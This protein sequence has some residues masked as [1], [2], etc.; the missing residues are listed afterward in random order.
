M[1]KLKYKI[2]Y[3]RTHLIVKRKFLMLFNI[4]SKSFSK[5][6]PS[7]L[8]SSIALN[9][10]GYATGP[11]C[12]P[13][14][15]KEIKSIYEPRIAQVVPKKTGAPFKNLMFD[16]DITI[17]NPII[18][19]AFSKGVL[20]PAIDYFGGKLLFESL[21]VLYSY[22]TQGDLRESQYWHKDCSDSKS[23][24]C[25]MYLNDVDEVKQGPFVF[26]NRTDSKK[27]KR[28]P[29]IRRINDEDFMKELGDGKVEFFY[30][31]A[32]ESV[33]VDPA[34][35]YHYG[36]RCQ[37]GRLAIFFTYNT[38]TPYIITPGLIQNN[39]NKLFEIGKTLRPDLSIEKLKILLNIN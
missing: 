10:I 7:V 34:V 3:L 38:S 27:M 11:N 28:S 8:E 12:S 16:E 36:S 4:N 9:N 23:F 33:F 30:G 13:E 25:I 22:P 19:L 2:N 37:K 20:D 15:L 5:P 14:I 18:K 39:K 24:H 26:V 29:L 21:Q 1:K 35:C 6:E 31:K 32:G 17:D